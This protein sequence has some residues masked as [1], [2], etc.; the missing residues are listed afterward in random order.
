MY[1][2]EL[3]DTI[4]ALRQREQREVTMVKKKEAVQREIQR[5][6]KVLQ[7]QRDLTE[8]IVMKS[9]DR[10]EMLGKK[11]ARINVLKGNEKVLS[12]Q[13]NQELQGLKKTN[14]V[15]R[16]TIKNLEEQCRR[17]RFLKYEAMNLNIFESESDKEE[18]D[19]RE[20]KT[21]SP[22]EAE[23]GEK[24]KKKSRWKRFIGFFTHSRKEK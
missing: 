18:E 23:C 3:T 15:L 22:Q 14:D 1:N 17:E 2:Q 5:L 13:Y 11:I 9:F 24:P 8:D 6:Q 19:Q 4:E 12:E 20:N 10:Q 16:T 7:S 21:D